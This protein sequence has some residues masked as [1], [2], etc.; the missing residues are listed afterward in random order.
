LHSS[1]APPCPEPSPATSEAKEDSLRRRYAFKL[2]GNVVA[3]P[4]T[5]VVQAVAPRM[6]GPT[7]YGNFSFLSTFFAQVVAFFES[8]ISA[9]F[10]SKLSQRQE[11][12][13]LLRFFWGAMA[14]VS[15]VVL[16]ATLAVHAAGFSGVVWPEQEVRFVWMAA[17]WGLLTWCSQVVN[18]AVDAYG[19]TVPGEMVRFQQKVV[20]FVLILG[21][22]WLHRSSLTEFFLYQYA[23]LLFLV[24]GWA[25]VLTR[26]GRHLFPRAALDAGEIR[27]YS[28]EF[29][30][31]S[32]P[33]M[34]LGVI[35]LIGGVLDRWLLQVFAGSVQQAFYGLSYQI[36]GLCFLVSGAMTPLFW[37]EI[38]KAFS[39]RNDDRMRALFERT[40]RWMYVVTAFLAAFIGSEAGRVSVLLGGQPFSE[41]AVPVAIMVFYPVHQTYGQITGS[42]LLATGQTRL[43]G[44]LGIVSV[45]LGLVVALWLLAPATAGGLGLGAT[46]L[47][48]KMVLVQVVSVNLQLWFI[49]RSLRISFRKFLFH[50]VYS[51]TLFAGV[52]VA[53]AKAVDAVV[54]NDLLA[55][56]SA[57]I[58]YAVGCAVVVLLVPSIVAMTRAELYLQASLMR[59][60]VTG[61]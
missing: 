10:Y 48:A 22:F 23:L 32:A 36:G 25:V 52:A 6:L 45:V 30:G 9:A 34:V 44:N 47:A 31:Y 7:L 37:R 53:S 60:R 17:V 58:L 39:E 19:L 12:P 50:Q 43:S 42:F 46:G 38:A 40:A 55:V 54:Q 59:A 33:L 51:L 21:M 26:G 3:L 35:A 41:A 61:G 14:V 29:W 57:G 5:F 1:P 24:G 13:G 20:A 18:K 56:A 8:G 16:V 28:R 49:T 11:E 2:G 27:R 15:A 4:L